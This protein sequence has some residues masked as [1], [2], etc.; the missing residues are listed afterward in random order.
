MP[1]QRRQQRASSCVPELD[2]MVVARRDQHRAVRRV[3]QGP[4]LLGMPGQR[5]DRLSPLGEVPR[6]NAAVS[7]REDDGLPI[8]REEQPSRISR[9]AG[10]LGEP[11]AGR[12][13]PDRRRHPLSARGKQLPIGREGRGRALTGAP[14]NGKGW[15]FIG[16]ST[17]N[18]VPSR[19]ADTV[20]RR[21]GCHRERTR[22]SSC[23]KSRRNRATPDD[24]FQNAIESECLTARV[25]PSGER[26]KSGGI[27][28]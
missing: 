20:T 18:T 3:S 15:R 5:R 24:T 4:D 22:A 14:S 13:I 25:A 10:E 21:S 1:L 28:K 19:C 27:P 2:G 9:L 8:P 7:A 6:T 17:I 16:T 11:P 23:W 12:R 26:A